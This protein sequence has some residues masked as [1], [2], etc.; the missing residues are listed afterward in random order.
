MPAATTPGLLDKRS[1]NALVELVSG[2]VRGVLLERQVV[3]GDQDMVGTEAGIDREHFMKA[4]QQRA[5]H[6]KQHER[7]RDL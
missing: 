2:D 1:I 5:R 4:A 7:D 3:A 6:G